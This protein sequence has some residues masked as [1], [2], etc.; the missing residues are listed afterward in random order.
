MYD[1]EV[2]G[3]VEALRYVESGCEI[4]ADDERYERFPRRGSGRQSR[5]MTYRVQPCS[6][7]IPSLARLTGQTRTRSYTL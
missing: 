5:G 7:L 6:F 4:L 2:V 1:A 3:R